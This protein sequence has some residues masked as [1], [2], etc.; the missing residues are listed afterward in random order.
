M[1]KKRNDAETVD[2]EVEGETVEA[3]EVVDE[4]VVRDPEIL[5]PKELPFVVTLP[6][7]ASKAQIEF[8]KVL[9]SY[10]YQN[11]TK[12]AVKKDTL[13][14]QLKAL[15]NAPDPVESNLKIVKKS[16]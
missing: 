14:K 15:K 12:W 10:A 7:D 16:L 11:P 9:N 1:S 13:I 3:T 2:V 4:I 6:A 8:A 5:R